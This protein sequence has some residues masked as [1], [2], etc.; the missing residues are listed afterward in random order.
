MA[1]CLCCSGKLYED[2]CEKLHL[3]KVTPNT[4][5]ALMR[6]RYVAFAC[7]DVNYLLETSSSK[8]ASQLT[9]DDLKETCEL[10]SFIRLD[11]IEAKENKVEFSALML[12]KNELHGLHEVSS[13]IKE[14]CSWKYDSGIMI[15]T[16]VVKLTR[17][18]TCPCGSG[19][20][21]KK[22]HMS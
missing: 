8:L 6:S 14:N 2:C 21:F 19:K 11:V 4:P 7:G 22:C 12:L 17:N 10:F 9:R 18:D 16:E 5:E 1:L 13:F 20:K 15:P 3:K